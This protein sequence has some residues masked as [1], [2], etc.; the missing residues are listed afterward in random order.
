MRD[1]VG[2]SVDEAPSGVWGGLTYATLI[3]NVEWKVAPEY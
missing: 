3:M 2:N 1:K